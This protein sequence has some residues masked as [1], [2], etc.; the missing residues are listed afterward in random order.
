MFAHFVFELLS[1]DGP[2]TE[3]A[4]DQFHHLQGASEVL[5]L[6]LIRP[7]D[8]ALPCGILTVLDVD[9]EGCF[10][11]LVVQYAHVL[12]ALPSLLFVSEIG[13]ASCRVRV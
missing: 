2:F 3:G 11:P 6:V 12:H 5:C 1:H 10:V 8:L 13:R 9:D 4:V 7:Y